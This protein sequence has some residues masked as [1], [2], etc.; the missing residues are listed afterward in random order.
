M[1]ETLKDLKVVIKYLERQALLL[2]KKCLTLFYLKNGLAF[3]NVSSQYVFEE[4]CSSAD[5]LSILKLIW[6]NSDLL[7]L[8]LKKINFIQF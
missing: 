1:G 3:P 8:K 6:K 7:L 5:G 4:R 2:C